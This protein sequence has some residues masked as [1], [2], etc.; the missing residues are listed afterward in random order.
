MDIDARLNMSFYK[1]IATISKEHNVY[2]VQNINDNHI[3]VKKILDVYNLDVYTSLA[4]NHVSSTPYIYELFQDN[5]KL[6]VIEE[7]ISGNTIEEILQKGYQFS[8]DEIKEITY[9]ICNILK[10]LHSRTPA[11]IHRDLKPS[12]IILTEEGNVILLDL[13]AAKQYSDN[14]TEDTTLLGTKGYA[15]PE[16]YGFGSSN[17][18]TDIYALGMVINT[19]LHGE[20]SPIPYENNE[21]SP[22]IHKCLKLQPE[23]R[24]KTVD[25]IISQ[26]EN[27]SAKIVTLPRSKRS[28]LPPGFRHFNPLNMIV[29]SV[30]YAFTFWLCLTF[31]VKNS[32]PVT[33]AIERFFCLIA[34]LGTYFI[35]NNYLGIHDYLPLCHSKN[36]LIRIVGI[37]LFDII[38]FFTVIFIMLA[39]CTSIL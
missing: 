36:I 4:Q 2:V 39:I 6:I 24:Y 34:F 26:L 16:Q 31:T 18:Q 27:K 3:Y 37:C 8:T 12:N 13:N 21:L 30:V 25:E 1:T 38:Y 9:K 7:Y 11:I 10:E 22:I 33:L 5:G 32:T 19:L 23:E 28:Y 20:F 14:K 17:T 29:A 35:S 15:A